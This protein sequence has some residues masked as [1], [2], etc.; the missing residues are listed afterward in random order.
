MRL[1]K[2]GDMLVWRAVSVA[3]LPAP[4]GG[5]LRQ[6]PERRH[7][8][9]HHLLRRPGRIYSTGMIQGVQ[10]INCVL[11]QFNASSPTSL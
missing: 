3:D 2:R 5:D 8:V 10:E 7:R 1:L 4:R 9:G 11:S 6:L